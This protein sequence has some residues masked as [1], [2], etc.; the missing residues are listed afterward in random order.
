MVDPDMESRRRRQR[1]EDLAIGVALAGEAL[2]GR[3]HWLEVVLVGE[4]RMW[5][6][7]VS[8]RG[9]SP[10]E[11]AAPV[12]GGPVLRASLVVEGRRASVGEGERSWRRREIRG[13]LWRSSMAAA[14]N[15]HKGREARPGVRRGWVA[16][17][18]DLDLA[19]REDHRQPRRQQRGGRRRHQNPC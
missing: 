19:S 17:S 16:P 13:K 2:V 5:A 4:G 6:G 8:S 9:A 11:G 3:G 12:R 1:R 7:R 15:L 10:S 18:A 14:G